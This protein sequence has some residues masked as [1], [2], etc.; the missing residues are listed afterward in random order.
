MKQ[1]LALTIVFLAIAGLIYS[2]TSPNILN[3][4]QNSN[5]PTQTSP[6]PTTTTPTTLK[7][8]QVTWHP[9]D[10]INQNIHAEGYLLTKESGYAVFS[11]ESSGSVTPHDLA[12]T[13]PGLD[14]LKFKQKYVLEGKFVFG[15]LESINKSPYHLEL[16]NPPTAL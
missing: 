4:K 10:F 7:I 6:T 16:S 2:K 15:G 12:V 13:G 3:K 14:T 1:T 5:L 11:D 9:D 8:G